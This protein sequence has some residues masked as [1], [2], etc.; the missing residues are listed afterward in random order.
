MNISFLLQEAEKNNEAIISMWHPNI[1]INLVTDFTNWVEGTVPFPLNE[2]KLKIF[3]K[4]NEIEMRCFTDIIF[5]IFLCL[6]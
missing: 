6:R 1:T 3:F 4:K 2:C 5:N